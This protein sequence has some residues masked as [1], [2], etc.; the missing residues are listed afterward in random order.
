MV[1]EWDQ[2]TN[3][4]EC[5]EP[6]KGRSDKKFCDDHCRSTFNN[7]RNR[8]DNNTIRKINLRLNRNRRI[9]KDLYSNGKK[10]VKHLELSNKGFCFTFYTHQHVT[11]RK[12]TYHL[13]FE[14]G[15]R[16]IENDFFLIIKKEVEI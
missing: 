6:L 7:R 16:K 4:I 3:C 12:N 9:L 1:N 15:Y 14:Y 5:N 2:S 11:T 8:M 13:C 10:K